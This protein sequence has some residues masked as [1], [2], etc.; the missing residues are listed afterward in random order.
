[1]KDSGNKFNLI[2]E[3]YKSILF[4]KRLFYPRKFDLSDDF[5]NAIKKEVKRLKKEGLSDSKIVEKLSKALHF[6]V[7]N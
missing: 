6:I 4:K 7:K 2:I 1:M 3:D 5:K